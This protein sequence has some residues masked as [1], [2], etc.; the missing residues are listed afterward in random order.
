MVD[1]PT[2]E[3]SGFSH[4]GPRMLCASETS[5]SDGRPDP[6]AAVEMWSVVQQA[7]VGAVSLRFPRLLAGAAAAT[8]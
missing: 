5:G 4:E 3:L 8:P 1:G 2:L 6:G 7:W